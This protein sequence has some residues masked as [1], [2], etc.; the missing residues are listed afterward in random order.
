MNDLCLKFDSE[1]AA[2]AALEAAGLTVDG[3]PAQGVWLD[4][5]GV[6]VRPLGEPDASGVQP[7][8]QLDGWHVNALLAGPVPEQLLPHVVSPAARVRV[9]A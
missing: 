8:E 3:A 5:V 9:W 7:V 1:A 6:I 4:V 2:L